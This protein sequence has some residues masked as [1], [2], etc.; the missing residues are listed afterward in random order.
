M[1]KVDLNWQKELSSE[2]DLLSKDQIKDIPDRSKECA[3]SSGLRFGWPRM[4]L[5]PFSGLPMRAEGQL[6][7]SSGALGR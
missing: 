6:L 4:P 1:R 3:S 5:L 2:V 7:P